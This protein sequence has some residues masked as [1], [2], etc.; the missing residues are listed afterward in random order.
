MGPITSVPD[1]LAVLQD[2]YFDAIA[3][4]TV[5]IQ[6]VGMTLE[7]AEQRESHLSPEV[8]SGHRCFLERGV[9]MKKAMLNQNAYLAKGSLRLCDVLAAL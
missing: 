1:L 3:K 4:R 9:L 8:G 7:F 5:V 6:A 2:V